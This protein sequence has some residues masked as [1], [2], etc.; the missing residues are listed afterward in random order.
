LKIL[1][2]RLFLSVLLVLPTAALAQTTH[3]VNQSSLTFS[4][5]NIA[6]N[7]GDTVQWVRSS[8]SHTVTNGTGSA[9]ANVGNLFDAPLNSSNTIFEFT[10]NSTGDFDYFCR[11]HEFANMK[12]VI[13]VNDVSSVD[14]IPN[15]VAVQLEV[16]HPNPF[17]PRA[18]IRFTLAEARPVDLS[19][20]DARGRL[21]KDLLTAEY[22][23]ASDHRVFWNGTDAAGAA[24]PSGTYLFRVRAGAHTETVKGMLVR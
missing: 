10:F 19:V 12:G 4:P 16:P 13:R 11:P 8:G 21:I 23:E 7:V 6:I 22:R 24:V 2:L 5:N 1:P 9:D 18:A 20:F 15:I 14:D 17:N 3:I